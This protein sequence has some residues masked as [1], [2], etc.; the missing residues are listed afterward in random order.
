MST[1]TIIAV[2]YLAPAAFVMLAVLT[3]QL[4]TPDSYEP[5]WRLV[6]LFPQDPA[7]LHERAAAVAAEFAAVH[8]Q[9]ARPLL[10]GQPS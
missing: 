10:M 3:I 6:P 9:L 4:T 1:P 5:R 2:V 7:V 8:R